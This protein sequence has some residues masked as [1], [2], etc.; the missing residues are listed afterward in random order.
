[1]FTPSKIGKGILQKVAPPIYNIKTESGG[2][3]VQ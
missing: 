3:E 1:M 2:G